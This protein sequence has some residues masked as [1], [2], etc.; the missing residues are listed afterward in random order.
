MTNIQSGTTTGG[1]SLLPW[2]ATTLFQKMAVPEVLLFLALVPAVLYGIWV[3]M[4]E[5]NQV[6][7]L[8]M[9]ICLSFGGLNLWI[10]NNLGTLFRVKSMLVPYF[11]YLA[12]I[13]L[14][15]LFSRFRNRNS[16]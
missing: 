6:A 4:H 2:Q 8:M 12:A 14:V 10:V 13:G 7:I 11:L 5:K 16:S 15:P 9:S 3:Q 1:R